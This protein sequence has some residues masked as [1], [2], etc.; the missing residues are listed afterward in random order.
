MGGGGRESSVYIISWTYAVLS[1]SSKV[2][3]VG[4]RPLPSRTYAVLSKSSKVGDLGGCLLP[5]R[6]FFLHF[7]ISEISIL[8]VNLQDRSGR[9]THN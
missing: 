6:T 7:T 4:G 2:G 1:M 9:T 5:S 3:D 8:T